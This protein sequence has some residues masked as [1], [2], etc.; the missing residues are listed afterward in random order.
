[1]CNTNQHP[2]P[3]KTRG[4]TPALLPSVWA[5]SLAWPPFWFRLPSQALGGCRGNMNAGSWTFFMY[6]TWTLCQKGGG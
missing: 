2:S 6:G 5:T 4:S 3:P 1:M